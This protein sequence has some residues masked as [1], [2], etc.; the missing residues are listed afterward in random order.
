MPK[1]IFVIGLVWRVVINTSL[2]GSSSVRSFF[3]LLKIV[4]MVYWKLASLGSSTVT[5]KMF[6]RV[7]INPSLS[8]I[9]LKLPNAPGTPRSDRMT[10]MRM[11]VMKRPIPSNQSPQC[12]HLSLLER[13]LCRRQCLLSCWRIS[14]SLCSN[15]RLPRRRVMN[16]CSNSLPLL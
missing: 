7:L 2:N 11:L 5:R 15:K 12:W 6:F 9:N 13:L 1:M 16:R 3:I 4:S 10:S 14:K 8:L